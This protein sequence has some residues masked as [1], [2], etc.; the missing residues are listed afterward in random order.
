MGQAAP[1]AIET[2]YAGCRFRS[3][4]EARWAVFFDHFGLTWQ[5]EPEGFELAERRRYLPDFYL[6][7][8][9]V[10]VE[11]K[12]SDDRMDMRRL[13]AACC[14]DGLAHRSSDTSRLGDRLIVLG[15]VPRPPYA[16]HHWLLRF[17]KGD[18]IGVAFQF[19]PAW[20]FRAVGD[21][22]LWGSDAGDFVAWGDAG[23]SVHGTPGVGVMHP[24]AAN[25]Y[26]AARS[27]R[28]EFGA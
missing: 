25:S 4:L 24:L 9:D 27:A 10:W 8:L 15:D 26:T 13:V 28:F 11:V 1:Q 23:R 19:H 21:E 17:W 12:G 20:P 5:Y 18:V 6:P 22:M 14:P 16:H 3:R 2:T 7:A